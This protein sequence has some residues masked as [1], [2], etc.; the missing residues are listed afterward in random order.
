MLPTFLSLCAICLFSSYA[1]GVQYTQSQLLPYA[2]VE[3]SNISAAIRLPLPWFCTNCLLDR[4]NHFLQLWGLLRFTSISL[5]RSLLAVSLLLESLLCTCTSINKSSLVLAIGVRM[6]Q[7][8]RLLSGKQ[9]VW[10]C[11]TYDRSCVSL[12]LS[13]I[14]NFECFFAQARTWN[15]TAV[16]EADHGTTTAY[17]TIEHHVKID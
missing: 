17:S 2:T 10:Q 1:Y 8:A 14:L 9:M 16:A 7:V 4:H 12:Q 13:D 15:R 5:W 3:F 11:K 6:P